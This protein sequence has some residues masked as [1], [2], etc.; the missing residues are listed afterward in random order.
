MNNNTF[1]FDRFG[2][3]IIR[4]FQRNPKSWIQSILIFC[5]IPLIFFLINLTDVEINV[6]LYHRTMFLS[7]LTNMAFIF[8]PFVLFYNFNHPKKGLSE[9]MLPASILEKYLVM[10]LTCIIIAPLSILVLYG[11]V[12]SLLALLFPKTLDR[13]AAQQFV[14]TRWTWDHLSQLFLTQQA[15]LFC[16]LLFSRRKVVKTGGVFIL[17]SILTLLIFGVGIAIWDS[18]SSF[19]ETESFNFDFKDRGLFEFYPNDHP[20]ITISQIVRIL[21]QIVLPTA[22]MI[23][24]YFVLKTKRY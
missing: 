20:F 18:H 1:Q 17:F 12:D 5:G 13:Y 9:I 3:L 22:L 6:S 19:T 7:L 2:K 10:Q 8:A 4:N 21:T 15:I 11:G 24:S 23:G 16:N 14:Q